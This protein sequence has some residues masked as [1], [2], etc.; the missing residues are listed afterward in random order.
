M[1]KTIGQEDKEKEEEN[2]SQNENEK[3]QEK[4]KEKDIKIKKVEEEKKEEE[5]K[6]K[7]I[8]QSK[9]RTIEK[10]KEKKQNETKKKEK[11]KEKEKE[12]TIQKK[13]L[14]PFPLIDFNLQKKILVT[15]PETKGGRIK[16]H[17][18]YE[19]IV[20]KENPKEEE[21]EETKK[22]KKKKKKKKKETI[23]R[24]YKVFLW[25]KSS[26]VSNYPGVII[27][28]MPGKKITSKFESEFI[29]MG[30]KKLEIFINRIERHPI[31]S[32]STIFQDFLYKNVNDIFK[33]KVNQN[34]PKNQTRVIPLD[35][36][37]DSC[38]VK[39]GDTAF[40]Q[41]KIDNWNKLEPILVIILFFYFFD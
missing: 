23:R 38:E 2:Q 18:S 1:E 11:E 22:S 21:E 16:K 10:K 6:E 41:Q 9:E 20:L 39:E 36:L 35:D 28:S 40:I 3:E 15:N 37:Y 26:L 8:K 31:L 13:D 12:K 7:E 29:Q 17:T 24:R 32:K 25:L 33:T 19:I 14:K 5:E 4:K 34:K 30:R 27:P